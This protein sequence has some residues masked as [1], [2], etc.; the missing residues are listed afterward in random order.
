M[1][2]IYNDKARRMI[3]A[4][5]AAG[6]APPGR[7]A[8]AGR[9]MRVQGWNVPDASADQSPRVPAGGRIDRRRCCRGGS[10]WRC[11]CR[12]TKA[13][14]GAQSFDVPADPTKELGRAVAA[15]GGYGSRSQFES[16][17]RWRFPTANEYTSWSMT[18]LDKMVGNLTASGLHFERHHGG[19]PPSTPAKHMLVVH[20][21]VGQA[22]K[23]TMADLKRFPTVT[24]KYFIE[25]SGNGLTEW[26]KPTL[27]TVQGTH[28]LISTSEWLLHPYLLCYHYHNHCHYKVL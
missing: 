17:V 23:F 20:G 28:G 8:R 6:S 18:P 12:G 22:K 2:V 5:T 24:R 10:G 27:K 21:M 16:E 4:M 9:G 19:I 11:P 1:N 14:P 3:E 15:D 7:A 13:P 26:N 25:C